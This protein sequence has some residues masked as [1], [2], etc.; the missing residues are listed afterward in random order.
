MTMS[1]LT[2]PLFLAGAVALCAVSAPAAT[3]VNWFKIISQGL[4]ATVPYDLGDGRR[5]GEEGFN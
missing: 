3:N 1:K 5:G 4:A 2:Q